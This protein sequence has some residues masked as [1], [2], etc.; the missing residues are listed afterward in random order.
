[1]KRTLKPFLMTAAVCLVV[2]FLTN[3]VSFLR[4]LVYG[5]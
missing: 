4:K 2:I 3:K 5:V 1:M